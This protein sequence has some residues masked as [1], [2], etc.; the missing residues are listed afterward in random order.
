MN[1]D[2]IQQA[3]G[4]QFCKLLQQVTVVTSTSHGHGYG[5]WKQPNS[6]LRSVKASMRFIIERSVCGGLVE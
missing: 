5:P 6:G 4:L 3:I 2:M 1:R